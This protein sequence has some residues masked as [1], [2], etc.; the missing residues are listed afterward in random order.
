MGNLRQTLAV[1]GNNTWKGPGVEVVLRWPEWGEQGGSGRA[2]PRGSRG[3]VVQG[4]R[5]LCSC[6]HVL[7][8][9]VRDLMDRDSNGCSIGDL[10]G[11]HCGIP[12]GIPGGRR[13]RCE[14]QREWRRAGESWSPSARACSCPRRGAQ[15][16]EGLPGL[17]APLTH[18]LRYTC[19]QGLSLVL[20]AVSRPLHSC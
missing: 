11:D 1:R 18:L 6:Q 16:R 7:N 15:R 10:L 17:S 5:P 8:R 14:P 13:R 3:Q 2:G 9:K 4:E 20:G 19:L 12:G